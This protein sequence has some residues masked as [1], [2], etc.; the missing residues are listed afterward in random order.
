MRI[1]EVNLE[2][3]QLLGVPILRTIAFGTVGIIV[4]LLMSTQR[5]QRK[6]LIKANILLGKHAET[7]EELAISRE[8]NRLARELHDTL[9]HTLSGQILSLEA[10]R[11]STP[12]EN[13]ELKNELAKLIDNSRFG[14]TETRRALKDLR[15]KQLEDL[16]LKASLE[17]MIIDAASRANCQTDLSFSDQIPSIPGAVEQ[18]IFRIAQEGLENIVRHAGASHIKMSLK[19]SGKKLHFNLEDDGAGFNTRKKAGEEKHGIQG[20]RERVSKNGGIFK[21]SSNKDKGTQIRAEFEVPDDSRSA[22]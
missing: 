3:I 7:L 12:S 22:M 4:G 18:C 6:K 9:A 5:T 17:Y 8:R 13:Y 20:M 2:T 11:L 14:L 10:L 21:I 16:G 1:E 15:S 19:Y